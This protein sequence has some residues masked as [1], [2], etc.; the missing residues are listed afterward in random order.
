MLE[1]WGRTGV[2]PAVIMSN[3]TLVMNDRE[4]LEPQSPSN[5]TDSGSK[6][7][8][9]VS[10]GLDSNGNPK[11]VKRRAAKACAA[12]RARYALK[13]HALKKLQKKSLSFTGEIIAGRRSVLAMNLLFGMLMTA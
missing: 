4:T 1:A 6:K 10:A 9:P 7:R 5:S 3:D 11:P 12:C 8:T 2:M 13:F